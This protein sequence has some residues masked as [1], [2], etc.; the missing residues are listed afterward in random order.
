MGRFEIWC[1]VREN[2]ICIMPYQLGSWLIFLGPATASPSQVTNLEIL[3]KKGMALMVEDYRNMKPSILRGQIRVLL[4]D[5]KV[6][7]AAKNAQ[8]VFNDQ[9]QTPAQRLQFAVGY[10]L[11]YAGADHLS[12][13]AAMQLHWIQFYLI[14]VLLFLAVVVSFVFCLLWCCLKFCYRRCCATR[15]IKEE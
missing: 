10:A 3:V 5:E 8:S 13:K 15:K 6:R 14:D 1:E 12:S 11:R 9:P 2:L 7:I 4:G